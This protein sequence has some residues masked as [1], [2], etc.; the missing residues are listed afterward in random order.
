VF[1]DL[2][3]RLGAAWLILDCPVT[4]DVAR[5]RL[6]EREQKGGDPSEADAEV[7]LG[8]WTALEPLTASERA[9]AVGGIG[10]EETEALLRDRLPELFSP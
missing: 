7:L 3:E 8:Q 4:L 5:Q 9:R 6:A 2:A 1:T 10:L